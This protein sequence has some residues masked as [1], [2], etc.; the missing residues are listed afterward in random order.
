MWAGKLTHRYAQ[1]SHGRKVRVDEIGYQHGLPVRGS[2][3]GASRLGLVEEVAQFVEEA[4]VVWR[5][6]YGK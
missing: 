4:F 6:L 3:G 5:V 1:P 2:A